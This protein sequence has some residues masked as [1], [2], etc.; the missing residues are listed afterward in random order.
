MLIHVNTEKQ[1]L[2]LFEGNQ[3]ILAYP[4]STALKGLGE[5]KDTDKTPRGWHI[6]RAKIGTGSPK[7]TVFIGRRPTGEIYSPALGLA[8]P[9]RDWILSRIMWLSGCELGFN[10]LG[11]VDTM[12]R[13][14]YIHG[15]PDEVTLDRPLSH[16][17]IRMHNDALIDL[18]DRVAVGTKIFIGESL[19]ELP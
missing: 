7:Y 2:Q 9:E 1:T 8:Y 19:R 16:G 12:Q 14:I 11:N 18:Y 15:C 17:C 10:R 5:E 6:I 4:V 13:Y 3:S